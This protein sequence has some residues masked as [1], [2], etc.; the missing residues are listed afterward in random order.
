M[1]QIILDT[2]TTGISTKDGHRI[3]EIGAVELI[4]RRLSGNNYHQYINPERKVDEGAFK[5][6][7]IEDSF[8]L[9]QPVFSQ[10]VDALI[11]YV[12]GAELI[13]HNAPF[14]V[15][16]LNFEFSLLANFN[17]C[18]ED[19]CKITDSLVIAKKLH[20]GQRNNL[21]ALCRRYYIDN[22]NRDLHGALLDSELLADVYLA[23]TGGQVSMNFLNENKSATENSEAIIRIDKERCS[24]IVIRAQTDEREAHEKILA[25]I[26][27]KSGKNLWNI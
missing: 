16:F 17:Q 27:Q 9:D 14:D 26:E 7:G 5:V 2:E 4:D 22:T 3:I 19:Y 23:M 25:L 11:N 10:I 13:M 8:L 1:R 12:D 21:N 6:H 20:P 18:I 15:G 24:G